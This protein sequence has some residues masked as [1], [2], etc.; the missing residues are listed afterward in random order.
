MMMIFTYTSCSADKTAAQLTCSVVHGSAAGIITYLDL[1][2]RSEQQ[3]SS[4]DIAAKTRPNQG[5]P[6]LDGRPQSSIMQCGPV[7]PK[8]ALSEA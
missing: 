7:L 3:L 2:T 8:E 1:G 4:L 5:R 6:C